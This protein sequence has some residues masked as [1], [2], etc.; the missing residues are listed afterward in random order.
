MQNHVG[1]G[2]C[3]DKIVAIEETS[4]EEKNETD[5]VEMKQAGDIQEND[6]RAE[7]TEGVKDDQMADLK[8]KILKLN[9]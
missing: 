8:V 9:K 4:E 3:E 1:T 6:D 2:L 5:E 7:I